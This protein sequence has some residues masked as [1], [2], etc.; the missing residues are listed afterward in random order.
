[1]P[2]NIEQEALGIRVDRGKTEANSKFMAKH[3][4][5]K[6]DNPNSKSVYGQQQ[7]IKYIE[8]SE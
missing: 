3:K 1:M 4:K 7:Y 6:R 5:S 8:K 2:K